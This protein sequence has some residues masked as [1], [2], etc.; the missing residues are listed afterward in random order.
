MEL[1]QAEDDR[2]RWIRRGISDLLE[3]KKKVGD[4]AKRFSRV[5]LVGGEKL[6]FITA[7][8]STKFD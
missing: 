4:L 3:E 5:S 8:V 7:N 1:R 6:G 2:V